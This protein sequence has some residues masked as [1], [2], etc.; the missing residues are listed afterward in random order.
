MDELDIAQRAGDMYRAAALSCFG[1]TVK[2]QGSRIC[3]DC[4]ELIPAARRKARPECTRC[5]GCQREFEEG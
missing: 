2:G 5:L 1:H 3:I 4:G